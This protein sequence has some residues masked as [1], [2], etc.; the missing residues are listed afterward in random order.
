MC[1]A[2]VPPVFSAPHEARE[3]SSS[4]ASSIFDGSFPFVA[5]LTTPPN[6]PH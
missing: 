6:P 3:S 2:H 1:R 4:L 5:G